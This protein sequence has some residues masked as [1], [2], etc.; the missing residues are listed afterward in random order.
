MKKRFLFGLT[1][2]CMIFLSMFLFGCE[3]N[4]NTDLK[5]PEFEDDDEVYNAYN[6]IQLKDIYFPEGILDTGLGMFIWDKNTKNWIRTDTEAGKAVFDKTKATTV[7]AH[8]MGGNGHSS[9]PDE[10]TEM[11]YNVV[12]FAWGTFSNEESVVWSYIADKIFFI[13]E[14]MRWLNNEDKFVSD[15]IPNVSVAEIYVAYY[16]DLFSAFPDYSGSEIMIYGHSYGCMLTMAVASCM[17]TLYNKGQMPAYMFPDVIN[18]LDPYFSAF[19]YANIVKWLPDDEQQVFGNA[20]KIIYQAGLKC[21][22]NGTAIGLFRTS[23][24]ICGP[25]TVNSFGTDVTGAYWDF[26]NSIVYSHLSDE[27]KDTVKNYMSRIHQ[28]GWDWFTDYYYQDQIL[29]DSTSTTGEEVYYMGMSYEAMYARAGI[30]YDVN[31]SGTEHNGYDDV[32]TSFFCD[33]D[34]EINDVANNESPEILAAYKT[35]KAKIAGFAYED[36]NGNGKFDDRICS[37]V[38]GVTVTI[39]NK[40]GQTIY[41]AA[42]EAN[43][44][45]EVET[46]VAGEYT[47]TFTAPEGRSVSTQEAK[48][49]VTDVERQLC[50]TNVIVQ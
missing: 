15:D 12:N 9:R 37:H 6:L 22:N 23:K 20:L 42:T 29:T 11:G 33:Y 18:L 4:Q 41:S 44:Y 49:I 35:G 19:S 36:K 2:F 21:R 13:N 10:Y 27:S 1:A 8:G 7:F 34:T 25:C 17:C 24:L 40:D 43:G 16:Y 46:D 47:I 28:Y 14:S 31:L 32:F 26:C 50:L 5:E 30:K 45:Y 39:K 38:A 48:V 3:K